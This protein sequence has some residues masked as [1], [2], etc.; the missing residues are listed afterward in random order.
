[1]GLRAKSKVPAL[2]A[3]AALKEANS[4]TVGRRTG[5]GYEARKPGVSGPPIASPIDQLATRRSDGHTGKDVVLTRGELAL[6][7]KGRRMS[8]ARSQQRP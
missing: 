3:R 8:G 7:L 4:E 1:M 6:R 5:S 2:P